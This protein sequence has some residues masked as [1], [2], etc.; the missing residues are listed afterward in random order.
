MLEA[1]PQDLTP[2]FWDVYI[3]QL[4]P[5]IH[6]RFI[7]ERLLNEGN[8]RTLQWLFS[9]Y[10]MNEILQAVRS[11][12]NLSRKTARYW[13]LYFNLKEEDMRCFGTSLT[14]PDNLF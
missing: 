3:E 12:R 13:Q 10:S 6:S 14:R 7:I 2:F 4:E 5:A 8:Q 9:T 1:L 11:S